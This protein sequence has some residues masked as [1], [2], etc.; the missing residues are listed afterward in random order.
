MTRRRAWDQINRWLPEITDDVQRISEIFGIES[1]RV[2][3]PDGVVDT[4]GAMSIIVNSDDKL[5]EAIGELRAAYKEHRYVKMTL[6][7]GKHRSLSANAISHVWYAAISKELGEQTPEEVRCECKLRYGVPILRAE[8]PD[9]R[10]MYDRAIKPHL[11]YEEK[12]Q[13]MRFL[14]VTSLMSREQMRRYLDTIQS[15]YAKRGVE[16]EAE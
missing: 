13:A 16:L 12:L 7:E 2:E 8:D 3:S 4:G 1:V 15:E 11:S 5:S 9:F 6:V 10:A 14:P